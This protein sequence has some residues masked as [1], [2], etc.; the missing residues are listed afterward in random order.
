MPVQIDQSFPK[1]V[2]KLT[3]NE[4]KRVWAFLAKFLEDQAHPSLSLERVTKTKNKHLWSARIS[5]ELRAIVYKE[6]DDWRVLHA[7][8]HDAAYQWAMTK[9][10]SR[11]SK[12]GALQIVEAPEILEQQ[13]QQAEVQDVADVGAVAQPSD[14]FSEHKDDYLVSLGVPD[15][16]LPLLRKV[17]TEAV[18]L[19]VIF[20]LPEDV[21]DRLIDLAAGEWVTPP[22][23]V[24]EQSLAK[25]ASERR[26]FAL[27]DNSDLLRMLE[28]PLA[29]WV[30]FLHPSQEK[31][32]M[33]DFK[34]PLKVTGSAGTG[35]TVV[36]LHRARYLARQ[37]KRVL[38]TSFVTTL[39]ENME[40]NLAL[41]CT[42]EEL[43][44]IKVSTIDSQALGLIQ[45]M[46][47]KPANSKQ[48]QKLIN[49]YS[50]TTC[51]LAD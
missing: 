20:E 28:A 38:L 9:Q 39:C 16:W 27:D 50:V 42:P 26:F 24:S 8:H 36:A 48:V 47:I 13:I 41:L 31:L 49:Q 6:G 30:A 29:T 14:I 12:T 5:Q 23:P 2:T 3:A 15:S 51:P 22:V 7:G 4:A 40:R 35:K 10:V 43:A 18:L 25:R 44:L 21:S 17:K 11:H 45:D 1:A 37:G 34:G 33:G 32:A 19:D 46:G